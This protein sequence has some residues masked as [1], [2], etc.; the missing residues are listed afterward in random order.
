MNDQKEEENNENNVV[1]DLEEPEEDDNVNK[2]SNLL[3]QAFEI[4]MAELSK[5]CEG[6]EPKVK[7]R[8]VQNQV[9]SIL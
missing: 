6:M 2:K 9:K 3:L 5:Q 1:V 7:E 8:G 4:D